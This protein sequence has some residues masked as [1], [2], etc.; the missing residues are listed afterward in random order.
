MMR[1]SHSESGSQ[2]GDRRCTRTGR[3]GSLTLRLSVL[4]DTVERLRV[5]DAARCRRG[6][7]RIV[8]AR[9]IAAAAA[10][11]DRI[12]SGGGACR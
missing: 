12:A 8:A 6:G 7:Q 10:G 1:I 3:R 11:R 4:R 2:T 9:R 5:V